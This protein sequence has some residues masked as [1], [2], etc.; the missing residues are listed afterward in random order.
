[1]KGMFRQTPAGERID[2]G[3]IIASR[4]HTGVSE[5]PIETWQAFG[6]GTMALASAMQFARLRT[7][8]TSQVLVPAYSCPDIIAAAQF[9]GLV[10]E[11]VDLAPGQTAPAKD[12]V[13]DAIRAGI[14]LVLVVDLFG[15]GHD[16]REI[17]AVARTCGAQV[18][19]DQAQCH[20]GPGAGNVSGDVDLVVVS[21]GRGKPASLLHGGA[22]WARDAASFRAFV[23]SNYR[24]Q[25]WSAAGTAIRAAAYNMALSPAIYGGIARLPFLRLGETRL[26][27][28]P[29]VV[30]LPARWTRCAAAQLQ[31]H[32]RH[33]DGRRRR[34]LELCDIVARSKLT[35]PADALAVA[36]SNGLNRLPVICRDPDQARRLCVAGASVGV[37]GMYGMTLPEFLGV[38]EASAAESLPYGYGLSR[39][40]I[41][42]PT[43][44]RMTGRPLER[45]TG[46]ISDCR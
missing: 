35:V 28:L 40:L 9:A 19:H 39:T 12:S 30:R 41:T 38:S 16:L 10:P 17:G 5:T 13:I 44:S 45:L 32:G 26:R 31:E 2:L 37:S 3:S 15:V 18:I 7:G 22:A 20:A 14:R 4:P 34:T 21:R 25:S 42:L 36:G 46:L 11:F 23:E 27:P 8:G 29:N 33:L 1:M 6:S 43:H 24:V